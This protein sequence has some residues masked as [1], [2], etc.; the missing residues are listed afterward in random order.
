MKSVHVKKLKQ[1][2]HW[3]ES[4]SLTEDKSASF[5]IPNQLF[6]FSLVSL[7]VWSSVTFKVGLYLS[8]I[9]FFDCWLI[10]Y[11]GC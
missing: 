7:D 10:H 1:E 5:T 4:K 6:H 8:H 2:L 3:F 11:E 9:I